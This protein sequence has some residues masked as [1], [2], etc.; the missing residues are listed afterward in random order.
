MLIY[1]EKVLCFW[2]LN[3]FYVF[4]ISISIFAYSFL[5]CLRLFT[6]IF[7]LLT[8]SDEPFQGCWQV[9]LCV[10]VCVCVC[11]CVYVCVRV[12]ES[13]G[14]QK[15]SSL[16]SSIN[17]L[18]W[19]NFTQLSTDISIFYWK[20]GN[21]AILSKTDIV[22]FHLGKKFCNFSIFK[23]CFDKH[24]HSFDDIRKNGYPRPS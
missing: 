3:L 19:W 15:A 14:E 17:V 1:S 11:V 7:L 4:N 13:G 23:D 16:K 18:Q 5:S 12:W 24:S 21:F 22:K 9:S 10:Y 2:F 20:S 8:Y 6:S